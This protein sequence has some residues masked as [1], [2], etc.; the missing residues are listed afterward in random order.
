MKRQKKGFTVVELMI[1]T[2]VF[3][4]ILLLALAGFLQ[5][6]HLF[7]KGVNIT[8]TTDVA[9]QIATSIKNDIAFDPEDTAIDLNSSP[10]IVDG[11]GTVNRQY[12]CAGSKRYAF[13]LGRQLDAA[14]QA[15]EMETGVS[16]W[17]KFALLKD[18]DEVSGCPDPFGGANSIDPN[19]PDNPV[20]E[21]LG[22]KMRLSN[23]TVCQ[24]GL[25]VAEW[26]PCPAG[27]ADVNLNS[28]YTL[29][30]RIAYGDNDVMNNPS[31]TTASCISSPAASRY[32]FV[33]D[34]RTTAKKGI[35]Q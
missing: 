10:V 12:F 1:A 11:I 26:P 30:V 34:L 28:L 6:G 7:Y 13:I 25:A 21:L 20:T 24:L 18:K 35:R 5:I 23:L 32:C 22:D 3:S 9:K 2:T 14:A 4:I 17:H 27:A 16:G 15:E 29:N 19:N 8:R 31:S 33:T